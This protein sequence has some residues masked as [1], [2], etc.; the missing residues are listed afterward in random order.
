M[1]KVCGVRGIFL[2]GWEDVR[3]P[4]EEINGSYIWGYHEETR[5]EARLAQMLRKA[6]VE[7]HQEAPLEGFTVDFLIENWLVV[8]VDGESHLTTK[9]KKKDER[10]QKRIEE[11][12][13]QV[14]RVET[15]SLGS[16]SGRKNTLSR[17]KKVLKLG[18]P[19]LRK[20]FY[21]D[22]DLAKQIS[23]IKKAL[24]LGEKERE[25]KEDL[26][27]EGPCGA[28]KGSPKEEESMEDYFGQEREDFGVLLENYDWPKDLE[29]DRTYTAPRSKRRGKRKSKRTRL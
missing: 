8:E 4:P 12:G 18:P 17:I 25:K 21:P 14:L 3:K 7:F 16:Q 11:L 28:K 2:K 24:R 26:A 6:G 22:E 13:F 20:K 19:Y 10:R 27:F 29:G 5:T 9:N 23:N 15:S 1:Q